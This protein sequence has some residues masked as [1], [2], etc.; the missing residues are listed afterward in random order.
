MLMQVGPVDEK[1]FLGAKSGMK[2][3]FFRPSW[4]DSG[5]FENFGENKTEAKL[6][7]QR[8]RDDLW[9]GQGTQ[10][11]RLDFVL[12]N[13]NVGQFAVVNLITEMTVTGLITPRVNIFARRYGY[14]QTNADWVRFACEIFV[15]IAWGYYVY[16]EYR[17]FR[18]AWK[19]QERVFAY[20]DVFWQQADAIHFTIFFICAILWLYI[21]ADPSVTQLQVSE[22][23]IL[24]DGGPVNFQATLQVVEVYF[25]LSGV[26]MLFAVVRLLR[27]LRM[28][29]FLGQ[30]TDAL[31]MMR[32]GLVQ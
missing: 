1:P 18:T 30:L 16:S 14:Y 29:A 26:N 13:P 32:D 2:Y 23:S 9:L 11:T 8:L 15:L 17:K 4:F 7:L 20:F 6:H 10:F 28:N 22:A 31:E 21:V 5:Y 25:A 24:M 19:D 12:Y 27:F 3:E